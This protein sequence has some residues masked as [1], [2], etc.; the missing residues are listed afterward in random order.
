M[1]SLRQQARPNPFDHLSPSQIKN[2]YPYQYQLAV[3]RKR[4]SGR[5][6]RTDSRACIAET[7]EARRAEQ[8]QRL[9]AMEATNAS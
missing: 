4:P 7:F 8:L 2:R 6:P 9:A 5:T 3:E 1:S